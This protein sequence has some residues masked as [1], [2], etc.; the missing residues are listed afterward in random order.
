MDTNCINNACNIKPN[1]KNG[2]NCTGLY[3]K[4]KYNKLE[5]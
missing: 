1:R 4:R 2:W 3:G 5:I